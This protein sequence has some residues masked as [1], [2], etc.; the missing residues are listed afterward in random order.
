MRLANPEFLWFLLLVPVLIIFIWWTHKLKLKA[1]RQMVGNELWPVMFA[2]YKSKRGV[3]KNILWIAGLLFLIFALVDPQIGTKTEE[4]KRK[5]VDIVVA[6]DVSLSMKANDIP[7]S[8]LAK[9][10]YQVQKLIEM[11]E[12][13]RIGLISFAGMAHPQCPLTID[14]AA[15]T[16]F[17]R[18]M[19]PDLLPVQGTAIGD[20]IKLANKMFNSEEKK[21]KVLIVF[22]DGE[23]LESD[24]LKAAKE[25]AAEG[26]VIHTI[27]VGTLQGA[28][29]PLGTK[30]F[31]K[32]KSGKVVITKLSDNTLRELAIIGNGK[33]VSVDSG[34]AGLE[35]IY[36]AVRKMQEKDLGAREFSD[37]EDRFQGFA[38]FALFLFIGAEL[39]PEKATNGKPKE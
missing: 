2:G 31:K 20:A 26:T 27:G 11:L 32:D 25:A 33:Y 5:G 37:Y 34:T 15:A 21:F 13:D 36:D 28:P 22:S 30:S 17:L 18:Q 29:I 24:P 6:L 23:D 19:D 12:G 39:I 10:K 1:M 38:L 3:F 9:A 8:R 16:L 14:Y 4:V 7:P 35:S